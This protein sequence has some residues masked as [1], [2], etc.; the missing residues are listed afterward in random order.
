MRKFTSGAT[1]DADSDKIDFEGF[2]CPLVIERYGQFMHQH[3]HQR[4]GTLRDSDNW[5]RG[6]PD[7]VYLKSAWRH[8]HAVWKAYRTGAAF[9]QEEACAVLFNISGLLHEDLKAYG[10]D[11]EKV[12]SDAS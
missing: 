5:Q 8:F 7:A 9:P 10:S 4:D 11:D 3:R 1:R 2:L 12:G 6:I